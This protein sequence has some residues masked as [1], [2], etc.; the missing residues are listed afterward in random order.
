MKYK[1]LITDHDDT[2]VNSTVEVHYPCMVECLQELRPGT[3]HTFDQFYDYNFHLGF[4]GYADRI[5]HFT[6]EEA[7]RQMQ[8][9]RKWTSTHRPTFFDGVS[10]LLSDFKAAGGILIVSSHS[11]KNVILNDFKNGGCPKPDEIYGWDLKP[12]QRKPST[13]TIEKITKRFGIQP[14]EMVMIDDMRHGLDMCKAAGVDFIFANWA[15]KPQ[16]LV[17]YMKSHSDFTASSP[18]EVRELIF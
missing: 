7:N 9:W 8:I 14:S 17:D 12:E 15:R 13:Y 6:P 2:L 3:I 16:Y 18:E 10:T 1:C 5:L 11:E 4:D